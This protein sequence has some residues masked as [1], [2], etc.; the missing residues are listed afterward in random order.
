MELQNSPIR[1]ARSRSGSI[2]TWS[3]SARAAGELP[4][5]RAIIAARRTIPGKRSRMIRLVKIAEL[6]GVSKQRAHQLAAER[7]FPAPVGQD[8][9]GRLW[10]RRDVAAWAKRWRNAKPWR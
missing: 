10:N 1:S 2:R 5:T 8:A 9:R 4:S 6:L 7:D 3:S